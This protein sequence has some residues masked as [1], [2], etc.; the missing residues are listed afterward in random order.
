[1]PTAGLTHHIV[2]TMD[3]SYII[4]IKLQCIKIIT[5]VSTLNISITINNISIMFQITHH[6][7]SHNFFHIF[8]YYRRLLWF[9]CVCLSKIIIILNWI[10]I[11]TFTLLKLM[12]GYIFIM[13]PHCSH[14]ETNPGKTTF[15]GMRILKNCFLCI[16]NQVCD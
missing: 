10:Y 4:N 6:W 2:H 11:K 8:I 12:L 7:M 14:S 15:W 16:Y 5:N 9:P 13:F 3:E 1:M